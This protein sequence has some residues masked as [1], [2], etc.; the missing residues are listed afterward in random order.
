MWIENPDL[1]TF[2]LSASLIGVLSLLLMRLSIDCRHCRT[3]FFGFFLLVGVATLIN[4]RQETNEWILT[5]GAL[6]TMT[7]GSVVETNRPQRSHA[8]DEST[9]SFS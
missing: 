6:A 7:I 8:S 1:F 3:I 4:L 2:S 9:R 5:A